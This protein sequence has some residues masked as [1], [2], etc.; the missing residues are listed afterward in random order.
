MIALSDVI[1]V[2]LAVDLDVTLVAKANFVD[3]VISIPIGEDSKLEFL[4]INRTRIIKY[5]VCRTL[6]DLV[7]IWVTAAIVVAMTG[8]QHQA[9]RQ[10][11][12]VVMEL[13]LPLQPLLELLS[14]QLNQ[15]PNQRCHRVY[16]K[17]VTI[18]VMVLLTLIMKQ[19]RVN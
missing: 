7:V 19:A 11:Q 10:Q 6:T 16:R 1:L 9:Q 5:W 3:F 13:Q 14:Q 8:A 2:V 18:T 17:S 12:L 4:I 15:P